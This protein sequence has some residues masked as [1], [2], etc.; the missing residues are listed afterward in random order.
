[1]TLENQ[2]RTRDSTRITLD[3]PTYSPTSELRAKYLQR[4]KDELESL[5]DHAEAEEWKPIM[6]IANHVRGTGAMYGFPD[7]GEAAENL[8]KAVQG[9][10]ANPMEYLEEYIKSV[11]E[12]YV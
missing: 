8:V 6:T 7:M 4:H 11:S 12:S 5:R 1:M 2:M 3:P 10:E 9:G